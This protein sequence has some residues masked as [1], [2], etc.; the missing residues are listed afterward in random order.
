MRVGSIFSGRGELEH[1]FVRVHGASVAFWAE[2]D[3]Y[4]RRILRHRYPHACG[5][6]DVR[7]VAGEAG[8]IDVLVGGFPCQDLSTANTK[9]RG[10][11]GPK[12]GLWSEFARVVSVLN[13]LYVVVENVA[14]PWRSWVPY[15]RRDL[16]IRGYT[17][18]PVRVRADLFGAP[19]KR[20]RILI[21]AR[22]HG[23]GQSTIQIHA[24]A[25]Y[26]PA[27]ARSLR[28]D[29]GPPPPGALGVAN[30]SRGDRDRLRVAGN[31]VMPELATLG[32]LLAFDWSPSLDPA[33]APSGGC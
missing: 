13:P 3:P 19:H 18:L 23:D 16:W 24:K 11:D 2:S 25:P 8:P 28:R 26:V 22:A 30:G 20:D 7:D 4:A 32:A 17:C 14:R 21:I 9:G 10:L 33:P 12:S 27:L 31:S 5:Y 1:A 29:W 15:V 6:N